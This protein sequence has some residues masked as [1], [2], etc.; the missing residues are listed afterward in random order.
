MS[1]LV[2]LTTCPS[3]PAPTPCKMFVCKTEE[4]RRT[5]LT[6]RSP[7]NAS[8]PSQALLARGGSVQIGHRDLF[9]GHTAHAP[10]GRLPGRRAVVLSVPLAR[11]LESLL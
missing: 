6:G 10:L 8:S 11:N 2:N 4:S 7:E 9:A 3:V 5:A 1:E